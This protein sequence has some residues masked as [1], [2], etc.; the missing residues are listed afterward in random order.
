M[1]QER[2]NELAILSIESKFLAKLDYDRLIEDFASRSA[3]R[4]R[5]R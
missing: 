2:L 5:F 4:H 3:R 1:S